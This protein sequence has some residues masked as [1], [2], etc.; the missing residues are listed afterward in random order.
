[1][2]LRK[3]VT[4]T[5][6]SSRAAKIFLAEVLAIREIA[7]RASR[8]ELSHKEHEEHKDCKG[9]IHAVNYASIPAKHKELAGVESR[10]HQSR[11]QSLQSPRCSQRLTISLGDL[12]ALCG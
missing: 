4:L 7:K 11:T 9:R 12:C 10:P 8:K 5:V 3:S 2:N 1:M 6:F